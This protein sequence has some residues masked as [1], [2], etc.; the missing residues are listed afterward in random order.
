MKRDVIGSTKGCESYTKFN[1]KLPKDSPAFP[2]TNTEDLK[3]TYYQ[4]MDL[5]SHGGIS[6]LMVADLALGYCFYK[7]LGKKTSA[8]L[9]CQQS[10]DN[11]P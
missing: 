9:S 10:Q 2:E 7:S 1:S 4:G 8:K 5:F 3:S 6:Y 11:I